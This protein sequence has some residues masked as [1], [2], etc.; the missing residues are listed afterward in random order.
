MFAPGAAVLHDGQAWVLLDDRPG[1]RLGAA[2]VWA[3]RTPAASLN[4][5]VD[6]DRADDL[7]TLA[8]QADAFTIPITVWSAAGRSLQPAAAT[9]LPVSEPAPAAHEELRGLIIAGGA[10]PLVEHGV[11]VG[12]VGGLE[13]CRVVDDP[14]LHTVRLEV[15]VGAHDR[16]AFQMMHGDVPTVESLSRIVRAVE[17]HRE[18]GAGP[19]P[20]KR[21]AAERLIRWQIQHRPEL[22][23]AVE[24]EPVAPPVPRP[25]LKDP[26]PCVAVG[27]DVDQR[28]MVV[29]CVSGVDLNVV[30]FATDARLAVAAVE[31]DWSNG[32]RLLVVMPERDRLAVID[33]LAAMLREPLELLSID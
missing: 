18:I 3:A 5:I 17:G 6:A 26:I 7:G 11:L 30:P 24:I 27:R 15:G 12:E 19:H 23:G 8:R 16:E 1:D 29:V 28:P 9:P 21:L 20:L 25:N 13:V 33:E 32:G 31:P 2:L 4:V 22:V 10:T 14:Y